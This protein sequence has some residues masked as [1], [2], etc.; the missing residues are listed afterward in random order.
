MSGGPSWRLDHDPFARP[1]G[2]HGKYGVSGVQR[3]KK[4][5]TDACTDCRESAAHYRRERRRGGIKP[6]TPQ[7][8]GT[9]GGAARHKA[10]GEP[11]CFKCKVAEAN[12]RVDLRERQRLAR[13]EALHAEGHRLAEQIIQ[14]R[15]RRCSHARKHTPGHCNSCGV[16]RTLRPGRTPTTR[17]AVTA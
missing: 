8:C 13:L 10:A 5:G 17:K 4:A 11:T 9:Y 3:H 7:P 15:R 14:R 12:Y 2:C 6:R 16:H 1:K